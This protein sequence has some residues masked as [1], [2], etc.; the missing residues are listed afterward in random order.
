[1]RRPLY[2]WHDPGIPG[3][4]S[5]LHQR[6]A[7]L[8]GRRRAL[9]LAPAAVLGAGLLG[10]AAWTRLRPGSDGSVVPIGGPFSLLDG[11]GRTVT[12]RDF[13]GR[14]MLVY[15][16]YTHC[17]DACPTALQDMATALDDLG[18]RRQ[19]VA[20]LFITVDPERD[21]P[22]VMKDYV[23]SFGAGITGLSGSTE[24]V[25]AAARAYR[26]YFAKQPK[27][28]GYDMDHSSIIYVMDR[29]GR[30]L[31]NFMHETPEQIAAKLRGLV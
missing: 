26:V 3:A 7:A 14:L 21:T 8:I 17:P 1:V 2:P 9:A 30:F 20:A 6:D 19:E 4:A 15:F 31:S 12:D 28:D 22:S 18:S 11:N 13:R 5:H 10:V 16:G 23:A 29:Q 25:M 24:A 27:A